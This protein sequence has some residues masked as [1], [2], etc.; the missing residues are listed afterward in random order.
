M[1]VSTFHLIQTLILI[2]IMIAIAIFCKLQSRKIERELKE[3][4]ESLDRWL[5]PPEEKDK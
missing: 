2:I 3:T 4:E 1:S 5:R